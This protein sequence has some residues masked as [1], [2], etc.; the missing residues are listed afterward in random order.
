MNNGGTTTASFYKERA[1]K[2]RVKSLIVTDFFKA[3]FPI[4]DRVYKSDV[5]YLDLFAG[6][7]RYED[8]EASTPLQL[9][10]VV[11]G[12]R[13][14]NIRQ[15]LRIVFN[16]KDA[17]YTG[18]L[19]QNIDAH[20]VISQLRHK[21]QVLNKS[22]GEIDLSSYTRGNLPIFTFIDPWG[23]KDVSAEQVWTLVRNLGSDCVIFFNANRILQDLSKP[24]NVQ[25]FQS[26]FGAEFDEAKRI[27]QDP[28]MPQPKKAELF[29]T[30]FSKNIYLTMKG[31][32]Y[33]DYHLFVLPFS[34]EADD[35]E[36]ISHY[37]LFVSK[38]HKAIQ[39]M[40]RV[41]LA[42][43]N[44]AA[45]AF[46]YDNKDAL[47]ITLFSRSDFSVD[48]IDKAINNMITAAPRLCEAK[49]TVDSLSEMLDRYEM[50]NRFCVLPCS[51]NEIKDAVEKLDGQGFIEP[52]FPQGKRIKKR[53]TYDREFQIKDTILG[54]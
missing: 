16:D 15:K 48:V 20:P 9:L 3:Y 53:I 43:G 28:S 42:H 51:R 24:A 7:G 38:A 45:G 26:V 50:S 30:L 34:F 14:D 11:Q 39:E 47:Q 2:S 12:F 37:I 4:I 54:K 41:M 46:G 10:D 29:F 18:T 35:K 6:P 1:E 23:Y 19:Q 13:D 40:R 36:K 22:A 52:I 27:Q 25:D 31:E 32:K 21:P 44:T 8:G 49:F 33:K 5:W 17:A